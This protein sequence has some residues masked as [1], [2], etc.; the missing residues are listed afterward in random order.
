MPVTNLENGARLISFDTSQGRQV[1]A[2]QNFTVEWVDAAQGGVSFE[3]R[4]EA[5]VIFPESG[6]GVAGPNGWTE[7][8]EAAVMITPPGRYEIVSDGSGI[9]L[10]IA[11]DRPDLDTATL[12]DAGVP[13]NDLIAPVGTPFTRRKPLDAPEVHAIAAIEAPEGNRRI[14]FLQS[15]TISVNLVLYNGPRGKGALSP[16][17]HA[18]I[19]QGSL[20][21][22]GQYVHHMRTPWG[23]DGA[24]WLDDAHVDASAGTMI[25]IPPE[26]VHTSEGVGPK[27]HFLIDIFAPPRRDFIGKGWVF[28]SEDYIDPSGQ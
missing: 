8:A 28:N 4:N 23:K 5:M 14:K 1:S 6:G 18:D 25:L 16:H 2:G 9:A 15:E 17:S 27:G 19:E 26:L 22:A 21:V 13:S 20:A 3:S 7:T 24:L 11:T 12:I 10:I